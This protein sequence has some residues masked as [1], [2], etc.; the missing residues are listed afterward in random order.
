MNMFIMID[1]LHLSPRVTCHAVRVI[2]I[3]IELIRIFK[4]KDVDWFREIVR[5]SSLSIL[6][7]SLLVTLH[8]FHIYPCIITGSF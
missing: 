7:C 1:P 3:R 8:I 5:F 6:F 4:N 2:S